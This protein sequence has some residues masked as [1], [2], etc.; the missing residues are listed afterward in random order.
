MKC[1][2]SAGNF[3][4]H[5]LFYSKIKTTYPGVHPPIS[6][7]ALRPKLGLWWSYHILDPILQVLTRLKKQ[8]KAQWVGGVKIVSHLIQ[9]N[10]SPKCFLRTRVF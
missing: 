10:H 6:P 2:L 3:Q 4:A 9:Y 8:H 1:D 5:F 7:L